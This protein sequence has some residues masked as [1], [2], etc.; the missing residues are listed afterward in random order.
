M[1]T[2]L[3]ILSEYC[4]QS[5]VEPEFVFRLQEVGLI[6]ISQSGEDYYIPETQLRDLERY[7]RWYYEL[8]I[9][10]EGIDVIQNLMT[11]MEQMQ[12]EILR[13]REKLKLVDF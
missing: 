13:L 5:Q 10:A 3:I 1:D 6:E 2:K 7:A 9:N 12:D 11:R 8:S 4:S